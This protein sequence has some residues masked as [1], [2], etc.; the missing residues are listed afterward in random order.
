PVLEKDEYH[1][2]HQHH[3][4]EEGMDDLVDAGADRGGGVEGYLVLDARRETRRD[5][6]HRLA[7]A[8][9]NLQCVGA[10]NLVDGDHRRRLPIEAP[11]RV[12]ENRAQPQTRDAREPHHRAVRVGANDDLTELLRGT[13]PAQRLNLIGEL[14]PLWRRRSTDLTRWLK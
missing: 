7:D 6:V 11:H 3:R 14:G 1:D 8:L 4:L 13:Q 2:D 5:F 12:V 10:G 9:L